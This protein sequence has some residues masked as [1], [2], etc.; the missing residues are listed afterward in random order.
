M[1]HVALRPR[2][3][4][5]QY[6][7]DAQDG[8]GNDDVFR[9]SLERRIAAHERNRDEHDDEQAERE[10]VREEANVVTVASVRCS[11]TGTRD[12]KRDPECGGQRDR[13]RRPNESF[14]VEHRC[15]AE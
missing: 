8:D 3:V 1:G 2:R 10:H 12:E 7:P 6:Q 4:V 14:P 13:R 15:C 9:A 11:A 5:V